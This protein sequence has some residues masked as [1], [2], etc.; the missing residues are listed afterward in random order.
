MDNQAYSHCWFFYNFKRIVN[1]ALLSWDYYRKDSSFLLCVFFFKVNSLKG[2][3]KQQ[4]LW[5]FF[6]VRK[7]GIWAGSESCQS[8]T[9]GSLSDH[10]VRKLLQLSFQSSCRLPWSHMSHITSL[11]PPPSD[12]TRSLLIKENQSGRSPYAAQFRKVEDSHL[13]THSKTGGAGRGH[14]KWPDDD[15]NGRC[16][17]E[18]RWP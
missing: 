14:S 13:G 4:K 8:G 3:G 9:S 12:T 2:G 6:P 18:W 5:I 17:Q 11:P 16:A 10:T 1:I 15:V 7:R